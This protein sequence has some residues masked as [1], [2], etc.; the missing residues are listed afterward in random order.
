MAAPISTYG[1]IFTIFVKTLIKG[2]EMGNLIAENLRNALNLLIDFDY[3]KRCAHFVGN[4]SLGRPVGSE[5]CYLLKDLLYSAIFSTLIAWV[6]TWFFSERVPILFDDLFT[7]GGL[8]VTAVARPLISTF[9]IAVFFEI[10][11]LFRGR[12]NLLSGTII[13]K[14]GL[15]FFT[16]MMPIGGIIFFIVMNKIFVEGP[17]REW[18]SI[19]ELYGFLII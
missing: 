15:Q 3:L 5:D 2:T 13:F 8:Y 16:V 18:Q 6:L 11:S 14:H 19:W 7:F 1:G 4:P 17:R 9:C 10:Y 12:S